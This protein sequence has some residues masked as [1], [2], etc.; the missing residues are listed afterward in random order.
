MALTSANMSMISKIPDLS[1]K[2][3]LHDGQ[4]CLIVSILC[5]LIFIKYMLNI[6]WDGRHL[7]HTSQY[8]NKID[9]TY[10]NYEICI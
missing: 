5:Q 9:G 3:I 10:Y 4:K 6:Y 8:Q 7:Y 1:R 2:I